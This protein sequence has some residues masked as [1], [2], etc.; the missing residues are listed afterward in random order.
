MKRER[1]K[2][3][4]RLHI[5]LFFIVL[6]GGLITF[7]VIRHKISSSS[8]IYKEY[9]NEIVEASE[10]Y[11][12]IKDIEIEEGGY[13]KVNINKLYD[14]GLISNEDIIKKCKGYSLMEY[15][16]DMYTDEYVVTHTAYITCGKKYT[17]KGYEQ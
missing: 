12:Q 3:I 10:N 4:T 15:D 11:Y 7:F 2:H 14:D 9:E 5:I 6:I 16:I 13:K 17:T 8:L 1:E